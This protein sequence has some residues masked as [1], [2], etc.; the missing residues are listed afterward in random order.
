[1][2]PV[3]RVHHPAIDQMAAQAGR[4]GD[5]DPAPLPGRRRASPRDRLHQSGKEK[6]RETEYA[7]EPVLAEHPYVR[8]VCG[9]AE[10]F[11]GLAGPDSQR[12]LDRGFHRHALRLESQLVII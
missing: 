2:P 6:T 9:V 12:L 11:L 3:H 7:E 4:R 5:I 10:Y 8:A 1:M